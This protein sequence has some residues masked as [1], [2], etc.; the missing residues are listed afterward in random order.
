[1]TSP[2]VF[3]VS[4][5]NE[6]ARQLLEVSFSSIRVEGEI[7]NL[8][9]PSSGHWYFTLKD[10][11][12]QIRCAMFRSR[13]SM[14]KFQPK[15]GD[16]VELRGKVSLYANRGDYQLIVDQ[17]KPAGEGALLL[18]Y[19][20]LK[21]KLAAEGLFD[22]QYK[23]PLPDKI[24]RVAVIT[25]PTGAAI[26]DIL[27]VLRRRWPLL[28]VDIYPAM[29]QGQ[30]ASIELTR[31]LNFANRDKKADIIIIGRGGG[32]LEDL[33]CFNDEHLARTI[34]TSALPVISAVGHEV[35]FTIADFVADKRAATPSA[36]AE[37]I[38]P[39]QQQMA[40]QTQQRLQRLQE[41]LRRQL[42]RYQTTLEQFTQRLR[43][44][45]QLLRQQSQRLDI[46]ELRLQQLQGQR[47]NQ[48]QLRLNQLNDRLN[49]QH[50]NRLVSQQQQKTHSLYQRLLQAIKQ[51]A[52]RK[53]HQ[54]SHQAALLQSFSPLNVLARGYSITRHPD[55]RVIDS[56]A[57]VQCDDIITT[58]VQQ[59]HITSKVIQI[60]TNADDNEPK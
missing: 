14:L 52:E 48:Q 15:E 34:A 45:Q 13:T 8:V 53:G 56:A 51:Q 28:S 60:E 5:L 47:L 42:H 37:L 26:H 55:G 19:E 57:A 7:S 6:R 23:R 54:L 35:D 46:A 27:T 1:M 31:A 2:A 59:G 44:P 39:D 12:A 33:W 25:S 9:R 30:Q 22:D 38:S 11:A 16:K 21:R 41:S 29:V 43:S 58:R 4:Q 49:N 20:Q 10:N 50:P 18:A 36:A 24:Q 3:T 32:S 17:M 40:L